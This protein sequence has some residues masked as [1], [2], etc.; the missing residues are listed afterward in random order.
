MQWLKLR[1]GN[2]RRVR[3]V[4]WLVKG[5]EEVEGG[6]EQS[7]D[8]H[9]FTYCSEKNLVCVIGFG[10]ICFMLEMNSYVKWIP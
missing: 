2:L 6:F 7:S 5:G 3:I 10:F 8:I 1:R 9:M 4:V